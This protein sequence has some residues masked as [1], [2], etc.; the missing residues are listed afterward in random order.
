MVHGYDFNSSNLMQGIED[1]GNHSSGKLKNTCNS[2][3]PDEM[4]YVVARFHEISW[5][6]IGNWNRAKAAD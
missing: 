4:C 5:Y 6:G 2:F 1:M 3:A